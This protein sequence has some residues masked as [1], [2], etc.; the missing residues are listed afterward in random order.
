MRPRVFP[1][2][3]SATTRG[4]FSAARSFNEAAG[5][6]RGRRS[7]PPRS[8]RSAG[9]FNEAAGIPR[10]RRPGDGRG[11]PGRSASMRPRVFPAEDRLAAVQG[12]VG[13][14]ASMRPRVFPAEDFPAQ[15]SRHVAVPGFNEAAGIPRGRRR[16]GDG[17]C[18][19]QAARF[20]EA[21]GIPRGRRF[22]V[23]GFGYHPDASMRPRV[24]PAEDMGVAVER[25][26]RPLASMRPRVFPAE[27]SRN[28]IR[29]SCNWRSFNEAA[30][31][32]RG[33]HVARVIIGQHPICFNE[34][35]GIPRGRPT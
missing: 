19:A 5:I 1:A 18:E 29:A 33:R 3:D 14:A 9:C 26:D 24:F 25:R 35:A 4:C 16:F 2:E 20:N 12:G 32:P 30:G 22:D 11:S 27:D 28:A 8:R 34:A 23:G 21:A 31:I 10:G 7:A 15:R 17:C 13:R 6:P